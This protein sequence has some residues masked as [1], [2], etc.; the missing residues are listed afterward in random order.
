MRGVAPVAISATSAGST[1]SS[2]SFVVTV[3]WC[4]A[5]P[6]ASSE[7]APTGDHVD[8][9]RSPRARNIRRLRQRQPLDPPV[10]HRQVDVRLDVTGTDAQ[11]IARRKADR[12]PADAM[13]VLDGTQS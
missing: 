12:A 2:P 7:T 5:R 11:L 9:S 13:N 1:C 6:G 4:R 8:P 10:H 3:I